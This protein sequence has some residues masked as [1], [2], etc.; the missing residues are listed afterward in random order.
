MRNKKA[1]GGSF[2]QNTIQRVW[3]KGLIVPGN[4][5]NVFRKDRCG[6]WMQRDKHGDT[7]HKYGWEIDHIKPL[8]KGGTDHIDNLQPLYWENN[9]NKGDN[10]PN[11][12]CKTKAA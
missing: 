12:Y 10:Y 8:S 11:W 3:E 5:P 4:D 7:S 6:D 9:R 1:I 2:D